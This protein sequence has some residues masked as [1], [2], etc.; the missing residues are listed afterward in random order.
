MQT[1]HDHDSLKNALTAMRADGASLALVPTMGALHAGH[2]ALVEAAKQQ[3]DRVAV[4]IFV[5]PTQFGPNEDLDAYPRQ[6]A[7]DSALLKEAGVDLLWAPTAEAMYPDGFETVIRVPDI[8]LGLC[9]GSRPGH[10]D[11]VATVV[12]K[13]LNQIG[14]DIAL[15]GE[16]DYQ[17]LAIIR[18]MVRD[19]DMTPQIVGVSTVRDDDGLA[20]S[21]RNAYL[22]PDERQRATT[23]PNAIREAIAAIEAGCEIAVALQLLIRRLS[24]ADFDPIDYAEIRNA[25]TLAPIMGEKIENGPIAARL[26]VAARLGKT[27]LIDNWP[28]MVP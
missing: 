12:C 2:M 11:G 24:E 22:T 6:L 20:L 5:N 4:S 15:F 27:R 28:L 10:F 1:V 7:E 21:S 16:K 9:G 14:P 25:D 26:L 19:L 3:A 8:S 18:R 23:L 17:Q 13:L